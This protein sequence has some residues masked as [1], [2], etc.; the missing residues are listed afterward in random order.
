[1]P[2]QEQK[3]SIERTDPRLPA[4]TA[5]IRKLDRY[6]ASLYPAESNHLVDVDALAQPTVRFFG[7]TV[8]GVYCGCGAIMLHG[9]DYAEVK[10]MFIEPVRRGL[11]LA[12]RLLQR[13]EDEARREGINLLRLETGP[14]QPEALGL[15]ARSGFV[16]CGPFGDYPVDDP[17]SV[18]MEKRI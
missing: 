17:N 12:A 1:M 2:D 10:R 11:G 15:F 4:L 13:L 8:D 7:V 5:M 14:L 16:R 9:R 18:F 6:M 3:I